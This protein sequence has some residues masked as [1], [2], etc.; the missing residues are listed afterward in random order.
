MMCRI[1][2][3]S[4]SGYYKWL[5]HPQ[6]KRVERKNKL[7]KTIREVFVN[8]KCLYGSVRLAV[9]INSDP[10][11]QKVSRT[12]VAKHMKALGL[13][14]KLRPKFVATTDSDHKEP[15]AENI[16]NRNFNPSE[17]GTVY[18]S[19]ITYLL[20]TEG[21]LYLTV[22]LDLFDRKVIGWSKSKSMTAGDTVIAA[23]RMAVKNRPPKPNAIFH[24][25]RGVQYAAL[26]TR[27]LLRSYGFTQSM[28]RKGNCWDNAPSESFFKSLKCEWIYGYKAKNM[29]QMELSVFSYIE[30]WYNRRRRHSALGNLTIDEF[31]AKKHKIS[32][33]A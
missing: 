6:G 29:E 1:L 15:V 19:D 7:Q 30:I 3:V 32:K 8:C 2:D 20:T 16:L 12:T 28:S 4:K 11:N 22:V 5:N 18:T 33:A 9:E 14:S 23:I 17:P 26:A 10:L 31:W 21:F 24:S 25:D 13:K 27:N